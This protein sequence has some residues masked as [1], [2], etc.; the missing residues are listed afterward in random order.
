MIGLAAIP[1]TN[2]ISAR[3][4]AMPAAR[5]AAVAA[6]SHSRSRRLVIVSRMRV[7]TMACAVSHA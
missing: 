3:P 5:A 2:R 6:V 7:R 1:A 4:P